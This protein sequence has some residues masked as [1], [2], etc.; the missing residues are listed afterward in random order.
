MNIGLAGTTHGEQSKPSLC[1]ETEQL[2]IVRLYDDS[3]N[4]RFAVLFS[5]LLAVSVALVLEFI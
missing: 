5:I 4:Y 1:Y 3:D 2:P